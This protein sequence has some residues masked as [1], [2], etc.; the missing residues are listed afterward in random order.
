MARIALTDRVATISAVEPLFRRAYSLAH[1]ARDFLFARSWSPTWSEVQP[2]PTAPD[3]LG[4]VRLFAIVSTYNEADI[5]AAS[6][7]NAFAQG[8]ERVYL[9]DNASTDDTVA[10]ATAAGAIVV[11][12]YETKQQEDRLRMTLMSAAVWHISS[13]ESDAHIWWL[14]MD[15]DEFSHGPGHLTIAEYLAT[16]DRRFRVVGADFYQHFPD[17]NPGY[18]PGFHPLDFQPMCEHFWQEFMPRCTIGHWK[19]PLARFD[20]TGPFL[21]PT[22]S[23]HAWSPNDRTRL[24]EPDIGIVT[25]HFQYRDEATTRRRLEA[26]WGTDSER[27]AQMLRTGSDAG[28]RRLRSL[29]AVYEHRWGDVDNNRHVP[30]DVGVSLQ[31]WSEFDPSF[32]LA[33]WYSIDDL[34]AARRAINE[35]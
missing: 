5:I 10:H 29:D 32:T 34:E 1:R 22:D 8:A 31:R 9:V 33:R 4:P 19:H 17:T 14:W 2:N 20:R 12:R 3:S 7:N 6:V 11:E 18:V 24:A 35:I 16:L 26:I 28:S 21:F 23:F 27:A 30:G 25:H 15:A 13:H